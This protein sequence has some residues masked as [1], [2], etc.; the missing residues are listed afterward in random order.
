MIFVLF[1]KERSAAARANGR[2]IVDS[3]A[4]ARRRAE[5]ADGAEGRARKAILL[6]EKE[7]KLAL[8]LKER[9]GGPEQRPEPRAKSIFT[10][11]HTAQQNR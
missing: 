9:S 2:D 10:G 8:L 5:V 11:A 6:F 7:A 3:G 4:R 1:V